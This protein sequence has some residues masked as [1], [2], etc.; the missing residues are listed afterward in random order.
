[1]RLIG[2][3]YGVFYLLVLAAIARCQNTTRANPVPPPDKVWLGGTFFW[4]EDSPAN[5]SS[6]VGRPV[7]LYQW[8]SSV[9]L[10]M[11]GDVGYLRG[12]VL[13]SPFPRAPKGSTD[14]GILILTI[15]PFGG[16]STVD[17]K[18]ISDIVSVCALL[19]QNGVDVLLRFAHEM[20]GDWYPWGIQ[21]TAYKA[22]FAALATAIHANATSTAMV[23]AP[24]IGTEYPFSVT[25]KAVNGTADFAAMDTNGD[26]VVNNSD[27]PY[28][29]WYPGDEH[30]D[31]V[32]MS[33]YWL[34]GTANFG[35]NAVP[36][37]RFLYNCLHGMNPVDGSTVLA[38]DFY[39]RYVVGRNKPFVLAET[40]A[41]FAASKG[42]PSELTIK[43]A[44][45]NQMV[46][47][48]ALD[49]LPMMKAVVLYENVVNVSGVPDM[50]DYTVTRKVD[51]R[52]AFTSDLNYT[53]FQWGSCS[54]ISG[55][56]P[57]YCP[58]T[59]TRTT[60][61]TVF[62]TTSPTVS[63]TSRL[64]PVNLATDTATRTSG[65]KRRFTGGQW[66]MLGTWVALFGGLM[67]LVSHVL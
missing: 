54:A 47:A 9:P 59:T 40:G 7:L 48:S 32:G 26:G 36:Y 62:T 21:P 30:V 61:Q 44:L 58:A 4:S 42:G 65:G 52:S 17:Q 6:R 51:Q 33:L 29:P 49:L 11:T 50:I 46:T 60:T 5:F 53:R 8:Y 43:R 12:K 35:N 64:P 45:W 31:W 19:N 23:W 3:L 37:P 34:G 66:T 15:E 13:N 24:N 28:E 10:D 57:S 67:V 22:A 41:L 27:D 14:R 25:S 39:G 55:F 2:G 63:I 18:T 20:N 56:L 16:L 38:P 1:M